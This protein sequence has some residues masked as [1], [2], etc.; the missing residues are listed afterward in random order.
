MTPMRADLL[1]LTDDSLITL[2][3]RGILKRAVKEN[4]T[5]PP[6]ISESADGTVEAVFAD[7]TRTTLAAGVTLEASPCSCGSTAVCRHRVMAVLRYRATAESSSAT[8]QFDA[9]DAQESDAG[10]TGDVLAPS[11]AAPTWSP[12]EFSDDQLRELLGARAFAAAR[13][14]HRTGYRATV[15]RGTPQDPVPAV[16]L[17]AVT[18][19]FLVPGDLGYARA[20]AARGVRPDAI[21]L[22]VWAFQVADD[23]DPAAGVLEV[24]VGAT[25]DGSVA[26]TASGSV[27]A[28]L[29]EL[30]NDG[31]AHAGPALPAVFSAALRTLDAASARWPHDALTDL[32][33]QLAAHRDRSAR[34]DPLHTATLI[35]ELVARHRA[36]TRD[37]I[38]VLGTEEAAQTPLR[39]L[40]LTGLGARITGDSESRTVETYLAHPEARIVLTLPYTTVIAE[41]AEPPTPAALAA[42]RTG[43]ARLADLATGNVVTESAARSA[44]RTVRLANS[45]VAR[46]SVLPSAGD[47]SS[48]PPEL[49]LTDLDAESARLTTLAP[50]LIRPRVRAESLRAITVESISDIRYLPGEQR[51]EATVHAPTGSATITRTHTSA[52]PGAIDALAHTL[53]GDAGL[54][55]Y[56]AGSLH[57]H[58]GRLILNPTAVVAG[59]TVHV[60]CFATATHTIP[61]GTATSHRD[62]LAEA[63][64]TALAL[65]SEVAHRGIRHLPPSWFTR[66]AESTTTLT[67]LGLRTAATALDDLRRTLT[68]TSVPAALDRWATTHLRLQLTADQL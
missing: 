16:E 39:H 1:A 11:S 64:T 12:A 43:A 15:H 58:H 37:W 2:A 9:A 63:I 32:L 31:V 38:P 44:N 62:P 36:S 57:R 3:N 34:H 49:L 56:I 66:A 41:G 67:R 46:T 27:L 65:T 52:T 5:A 17:S 35:T 61:A 48:L 7:G 18:V 13:K 54:L 42:R 10:S 21:A 29:A 33:D 50:A 14:A 20:D 28:P 51:L 60:P 19:R 26:V 30:L 40:R 53:S 45:R 8:A 4:A 24:T 22:A 47:W 59:A 23:L 25:A 6:E 55:R 68:T